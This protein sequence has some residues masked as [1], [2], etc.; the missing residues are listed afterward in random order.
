MSEQKN[1]RTEKMEQNMAHVLEIWLANPL[2]SF[3]EIAE[4]AGTSE[5]TFA[6]YRANE[7]FMSEYDTR[8]RERFRALQAKAMETMEIMIEDKNWNATKY[9]LDGND[10]GGKQK[11]EINT[12]TIKVSIDEE[13]GE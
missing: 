1:K 11:L 9:A 3:R 8:C 12:T 13:E 6:R 10:Y 2:L 5:R 7:A 4:K